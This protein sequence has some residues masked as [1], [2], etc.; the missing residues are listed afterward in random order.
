MGYGSLSQDLQPRSVETLAH[1]LELVI[2]RWGHNPPFDE[3]ITMTSEAM[4]DLCKR[5]LALEAA[6]SDF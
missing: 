5:L 6:V 4:L 2:N 1:S 3:A